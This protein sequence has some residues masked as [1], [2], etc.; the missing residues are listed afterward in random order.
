VRID[1]RAEAARRAPPLSAAAAAAARQSVSR[2]K[3]ASQPGASVPSACGEP[4]PA[5]TAPATFGLPAYLPWHVM[6]RSSPPGQPSG[7]SVGLVGGGSSAP[8]CAPIRYLRLDSTRGRG[9]AASHRNRE[10][11]TGAA[12]NEAGEKPGEQPT[13]RKGEP[14]DPVEAKER[15]PRP[16]PTAPPN[17]LADSQAPGCCRMP[18]NHMGL[19][20]LSS[21]LRPFLAVSPSPLAGHAGSSGGRRGARR[22][23]C[24]DAPSETSG[25][26]VLVSHL[27]N[28]V[29]PPPCSARP[30]VLKH[31]GRASGAC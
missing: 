3:P 2:Q 1:Q 19:A 20:Q 4:L 21:S 9:G 11:T 14:E 31:P 29:S 24:A 5:P 27:D 30:P 10:S 23:R 26:S 16:S 13:E 25:L 22:V 28:A 6:R 12:G 8:P 15:A 7:Q 18:C 17:R